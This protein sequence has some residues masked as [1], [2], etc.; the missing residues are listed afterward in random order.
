MKTLGIIVPFY[1]NL[2]YFYELFD[3]IQ[4]QTSSSYEVLIVDDSGKGVIQRIVDEE[5]K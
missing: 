3:S 2:E 5:I 4:R 1:R